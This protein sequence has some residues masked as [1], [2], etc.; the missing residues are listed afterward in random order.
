[1]N[2]QKFQELTKEDQDKLVNNIFQV[3]KKH[4]INADILAVTEV[5]YNV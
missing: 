1:M 3:G 2:S 4:G 5:V